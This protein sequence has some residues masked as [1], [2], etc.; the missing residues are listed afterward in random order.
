MIVA[1]V[2]RKSGGQAGEEIEA[3]LR[4]LLPPSRVFSLPET[5]PERALVACQKTLHSQGDYRVLVC[6]GDGT[7]AWVLSAIDN[8][9]GIDTDGNASRNDPLS[10][11]PPVAV[12]PL[13]TGTYTLSHYQIN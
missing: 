1:F 10:Y 2:N 11:R 12:L 7:V 13:G 3:H 8:V 4:R 5:S 6:G 9:V